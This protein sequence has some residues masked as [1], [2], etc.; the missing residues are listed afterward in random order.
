MEVVYDWEMYH[1]LKGVAKLAV[2]EELYAEMEN[3]IIS[4]F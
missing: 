2:F 4:E 1:C 3:D